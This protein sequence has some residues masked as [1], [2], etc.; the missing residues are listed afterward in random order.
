MTDPTNIYINYAKWYRE[1][2]SYRKY[3]YN[4]QSGGGNSFHYPRN[5][6]YYEEEIEVKNNG[7]KIVEVSLGE[8]VIN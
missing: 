5:V 7:F 2:Y 8:D 6:K 3:M 4:T 1:R